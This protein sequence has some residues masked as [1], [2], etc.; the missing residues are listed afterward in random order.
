M[1]TNNSAIINRAK[2]HALQYSKSW[3]GRLECGKFLCH[4]CFGTVTVTYNSP[5]HF[6]RIFPAKFIRSVAR[7]NSRNT[8]NS[9]TVTI[10]TDSKSIFTHTQE[11][12]IT[13]VLRMYCTYY[14][15]EKC[16]EGALRNTIL[17]R[18]PW[19]YKRPRSASSRSYAYI[20]R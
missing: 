6:P 8:F 16:A 14:V 7:Y 5:P 3:Y 19:W 4:F 15:I 11:S 9:Y 2:Y 12:R 10:A 18:R 1:N 17:R 20:P 13:S